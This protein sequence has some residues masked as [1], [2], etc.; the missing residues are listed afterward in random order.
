MTGNRW[1]I[2]NPREHL[3]DIL[4]DNE[5]SYAYTRLC[6]PFLHVYTKDLKVDMY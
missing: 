3:K 4:R 2:V 5:A 6:Y 1:H